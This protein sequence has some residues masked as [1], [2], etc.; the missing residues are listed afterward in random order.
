M[1]ITCLGLFLVIT[2]KKAVNHPR[3]KESNSDLDS[4]T[5][6]DTIGIADAACFIYSSRILYFPF[7]HNKQLLNQI[8]FKYKN[9]GNFSK[10]E[11]K[12][13]EE[14]ELRGHYDR[15]KKLSKN[16]N[17]QGLWS[18]KNEMQLK[19][20]LNGFMYIRYTNMAKEG[21]RRY[22]CV[23]V[24]KVFDL[25]H[26]KEVELSDVTTLP[27]KALFALL[28]KNMDN[29]FFG[30]TEEDPK[31]ATPTHHR[32]VLRGFREISHVNN[33][34]F[35]KKGLYFHYNP[36]E[37]TASSP[38]DVVISVYWKQL[39]S[40]VQPEFKKRMNISDSPSE[41]DDEF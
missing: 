6:H 12:I 17:I 10:P 39:G 2:C 40:S 25:M 35:D 23:Y 9:T 32:F 30:V 20:I 7:I 34:Y 33:F 16:K 3:S 41:D 31:K 4:V 15:L 22:R 8:Y 11:L 29:I 28:K 1:I 5:I 19:Y 26:N 37:L 21:D 14:R 27:K 38:V 18:F 13:N 24:D 36:Y